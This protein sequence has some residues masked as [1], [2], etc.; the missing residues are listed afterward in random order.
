MGLRGTIPRSG[1]TGALAGQRRVG[2]PPSVSR[3][4]HIRRRQAS[5]EGSHS[6]PRKS[7]E[8]LPR[9]R[10]VP[11][12]PFPPPQSQLRPRPLAPPRI[13]PGPRKT[14]NVS[15]H[16]LGARR[17]PSRAA[18]HDRPGHLVR[19]EGGGEGRE[20]NGEPGAG[21]ELKGA[22]AV[23]QQPR[24]GESCLKGRGL[25][26]ATQRDGRGRES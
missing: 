8:P 7:P 1:C 11:A 22:V 6:F 19:A 13:W 18:P 21:L 26:T 5:S 17:S 10:P 23:A 14:R 3:V 20:G 25:K 24:P 4:P 15:S 16:P 12:H 2:T 9:I